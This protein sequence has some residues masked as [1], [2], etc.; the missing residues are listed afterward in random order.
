M[1]DRLNDDWESLFEQLPLDTSVREEH[2]ESLKARVLGAHASVSTPRSHRRGLKDLGK[3]LMRYKAPHWTAA[4][5]LVICMVWLARNGSTPAFAVD[6]VVENFMNARTARYDMTVTVIGQPP[7]KM[8]A[9]YLAPSHFRQELINGLINVSDWKAGKMVGLDPNTKHATVINLVNIPEDAKQKMQ[10]NQFDMVRESL[11]KAI[12][13][14]DTNVESLGEK[15]FDGRTLVGFRFKTGSQPMTVWADPRTKYPVR[16]E[17]VIAG[18]PET[19]IV[20]TNYEFEIDLDKSLFSVTVPEGYRVVETDVD[21]SPPNEQDF[22]TA[23]RMCGKASD[24][25]FPDGVGPAAIA[26]YVATYLVK[27]GITKDQGP[28][29]EQMKEVVRIARGFNFA[30]TQPAE[31][32]AHYA[33]AGAKP[34][35]GDRAIFWYKQ[36]DSTKYRV[37]H[38]DF[39]VKMSDVAPEVAGAQKLIP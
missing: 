31:S 17:A 38:A 1:N 19:K 7:R 3:I 36:A 37:I 28:T 33:G 2:R 22:I 35:D 30:L 11:R 34:G 27:Q 5:I 9:F 26:S 29:A 10:A 18:P 12:A 15:E 6:E 14:S 32:D 8:K 4:T 25:K 20:M 13:D 24:G 39:S 23:L 16:I 21:V